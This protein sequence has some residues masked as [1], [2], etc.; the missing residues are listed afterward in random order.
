MKKGVIEHEGEICRISPEGMKVKVISKSACAAC[1]A[2]GLCGS[3]DTKE[4]FI[5]IKRGDFAAEDKDSFKV[6]DKVMVNMEESLGMRAVWIVYGV[7]TFILV[8]IL[9]YL[10]SLNVRELVIGIAAIGAIALYFF[11]L[12]LFRSRL[13]RR[14]RFTVYKI[15]NN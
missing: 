2:K 13:G 9:V 5:D 7:P 15:D 1:H 3:S 6:G 4:K 14:F 8:T 11:L 10:Q 12:Y